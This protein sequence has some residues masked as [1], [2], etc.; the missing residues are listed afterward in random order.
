MRYQKNILNVTT[1]KFAPRYLENVIQL[2]IM[3]EFYFLD[4]KIKKKFKGSELGMG[5]IGP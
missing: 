3:R 1:R 5:L 2:S 4:L